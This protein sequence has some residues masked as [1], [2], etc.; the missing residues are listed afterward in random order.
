MRLSLSIFLMP[1][2][3]GEI[4]RISDHNNKR[5]IF[6]GKKVMCPEIDA[7]V[8]TVWT[9]NERIIIEIV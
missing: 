6:E 7:D 3:G 5:T 8:V 1:I 9:N 2:D 4:V